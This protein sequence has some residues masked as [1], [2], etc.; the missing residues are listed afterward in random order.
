MRAVFFRGL[1]LS[2]IFI[3]LSAIPKT[4]FSEDLC[5]QLKWFH[6]SALFFIITGMEI[7]HKK[8]LIRSDLFS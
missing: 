5:V 2:V 3:V 7:M 6:Q 1:L 8:G 4:A